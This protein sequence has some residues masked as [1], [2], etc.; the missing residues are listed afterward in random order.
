[1]TGIRLH[2]LAALAGIGL[3]AVSATAQDF[4]KQYGASGGGSVSIHNVSGDVVVKGYNGAQIIV[5]GYKTGPDRE[6]VS[7]ED[8]SQGD[9]VELRAQYPRNCNCDASIK[10]EIQ[11]PRSISYTVGPLSTASGDISVTDVTGQVSL[12]SASGN[13]L[14]QRVTGQVNAS[15]ASGD[16]EV[17]DVVGPVSA[18][19]SSGNVAAK[20]GQLDQSGE[21][22]FT[23]ASGDVRVEVPSS[24]GADV[25]MHTVSGSLK[26]DFPLQITAPRYGPSRSARGRIGDGSHVM[27]ISS[28]S[29]DVTLSSRLN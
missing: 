28:A 6:M 7:V 18:R 11:V 9:R 8:L 1:M 12:R 2:L 22:V 13:V 16:V 24:L 15:T 17:D 4:H 5:D 25:E 19:S 26:T 20:L 27:R 29:G 23:T 10:F 14:V 21:L 3:T